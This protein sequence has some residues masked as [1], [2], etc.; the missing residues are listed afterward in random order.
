MHCNHCGKEHEPHL[1]FCPVTGKVL[2]PELL[3]P[4]GTMLEGKYRLDR[5]IGVGGIGAVFE[6][7]HTLLKKRVAVKLLLPEFASD[8]ELTKRLIRE[9]RAASAT[10]H[11]N[12]VTVSD[13]GHS[14]DG[15]LFV[16]MEYI[17]GHTLKKLIAS[18]A[19][20]VVPR[21]AKL[22]D[23][24]LS[25]LEV[26]H[27]KG[28][29][30]RDLKPANL[31]VLIDDAG[32]EVVKVLDFGIS[33][34]MNDERIS[35][36]TTVGKVMGTPRYM[37]PEQAVGEEDIDHRADVYSCGVILYELLTGRPQFRAATYNEMVALLLHGE[38]APPSS[39]NGKVPRGLD[40]VVLG[41]LERS[42]EKRYTD[43]SSFRRALR[44]FLEDNV[45]DRTRQGVG[46]ALVAAD[47]VFFAKPA[48][49]PDGTDEPEPPTARVAPERKEGAR[50]MAARMQDPPETVSFCGVD[51]EELLEPAAEPGDTERD[52]SPPTEQDA[53]PV[54]RLVPPETGERFAPPETEDE[55]LELV[56][57]AS[58]VEAAPA[59]QRTAAPT[60]EANIYRPSS[61]SGVAG[62]LGW[63]AFLAALVVGGLLVWHYWEDIFGSTRP[64]G[65][66]S[67]LILV[68][69]EPKNAEIFVDGVLAVT[70]PIQLPRT[71]RSFRVRVR[72][73]G[74]VTEEIDVPGDRT[75][76]VKVKLKRRRR[77]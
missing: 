64:G 51:R 3:Y 71:E 1:R 69:T 12:I 29:I 70:R 47:H 48:P 49:N 34:V 22:V 62:Y 5:L 53:R 21:A 52:L 56:E 57:V 27:R 77:R 32:D 74:Y 46:P 61:S 28:I 4:V 8:Q 19:P 76:V 15:A 58:Q 20:L 66:E 7:T 10:G 54:A 59:F 14:D 36:L 33:K 30:H 18:E 42:R 23:Q 72:A 35:M 45:G 24:V 68:E 43:A 17:T 38:V 55:P 2:S 13:M 25:A 75:R 41:A 44:P 73:R 40:G 31:L 50:A 6:A 37:S 65:S 9:A 67:V 11:P 39:V 26:V 60:A 16:V 63:A